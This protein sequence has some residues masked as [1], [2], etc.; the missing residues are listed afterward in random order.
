ME[1]LIEPEEKMKPLTG[2]APVP[3]SYEFLK[4][5]SIMRKAIGAKASIGRCELRFLHSNLFLTC[6]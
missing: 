1:G 5:C 4:G 6:T 3:F 2:S